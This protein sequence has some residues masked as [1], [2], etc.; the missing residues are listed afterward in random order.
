MLPSRGVMVSRAV[1]PPRISTGRQTHNYRRPS[2]APTYYPPPLQQSQGLPK[3][4]LK[5][6]APGTYLRLRK[7]PAS[8]RICAKGATQDKAAKRGVCGAKTVWVKTKSKEVVTTALEAGLDTFLFDQGAGD[9]LIKAWG[10]LGRFTAVQRSKDGKLVSDDGAHVGSV[11]A[12]NGAADLA[13]VTKQAQSSQGM[14]LTEFG[15]DSWQIIPAENLVAAFQSSQAEVLATCRGASD[16]RLMLG[17]LELGT[18][19]IVLETEDPSEV[20]AL[21][22][23]LRERSFEGSKIEL[24]AATVTTVKPVGMGDRVCVDTCSLLVPGE[25]LLVGNFARALFLVHSEC[26]ESSY[27]SSRPFR[28]NAGPVHAYTQSVEGKTAYL[29]ELS[30]GS[31]VMV[32]DALG[33]ARS[34]IVGRL[35]VEVRP[36]VLVEAATKDGKTH[37]ILL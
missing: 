17:A 2:P 4:T 35:K 19:G 1:L 12:I 30:S 15:S 37:S 5:L 21:S 18:S 32:V 7:S 13:K 29:S 33:R 14:P 9:S 26:A 27:I 34:A 6:T 23:F 22:S 10:E 25:G 31:Q 24:E 11:V 8:S 20:R 28:V 36:L 3:Q 16:A